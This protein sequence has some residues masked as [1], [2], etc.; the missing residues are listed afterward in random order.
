MVDWQWKKL[1]WTSNR[2][3]GFCLFPKVWGGQ[4]SDLSI[5]QKKLE[6][7]DIEAIIIQENLNSIRRAAEKFVMVIRLKDNVWQIVSLKKNWRCKEDREYQIWGT[8]DC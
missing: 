6:N 2:W 7:G 4:K 8:G 3:Q 5:E 1:K